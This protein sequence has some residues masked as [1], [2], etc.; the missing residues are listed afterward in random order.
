MLEGNNVNLVIPTGTITYDTIYNGSL[1][2]D[3]LLKTSTEKFTV[4]TFSIPQY[5]T[6]VND[7]EKQYGYRDWYVSSTDCPH[8]T[9][10]NH[11]GMYYG[12]DYAKVVYKFN[13]P[14]AQSI[15]I[16][17]TS[18]SNAVNELIASHYNETHVLD[19]RYYRKTYGER[20]DAQKYMEK[21]HLT[22][23]LIIGDLPSL[24]YVREE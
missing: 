8:K 4:Y 17:S 18:F 5:K 7:V 9:Y 24:G 20:I 10:S 6:F 2:R 21:N 11:Y 19:F 12:D 14:S 15:L 22:K 3:N 23:L 1:S 16:I 13:N